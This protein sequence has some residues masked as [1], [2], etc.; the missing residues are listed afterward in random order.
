MLPHSGPFSTY[1]LC[2]HFLWSVTSRLL[3]RCL[4]AHGLHLPRRTLEN[5]ATREVGSSG[6][7]LRHPTPYLLAG[8][9]TRG[10]R[11][12]CSGKRAGNTL[13]LSAGVCGRTRCAPIQSSAAACGIAASMVLLMTEPRGIFVFWR[14]G[15]DVYVQWHSQQTRPPSEKRKRLRWRAGELQGQGRGDRLS[16]PG[17]NPPL[18]PDGEFQLRLEH[19]KPKHRGKVHLPAVFVCNLLKMGLVANGT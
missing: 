18:S 5:G 19:P 8:A 1:S 11:V 14:F 15:V 6:R 16:A 2:S 4:T 10:E 3:R 9:P 13:L 7:W 17:T 12:R